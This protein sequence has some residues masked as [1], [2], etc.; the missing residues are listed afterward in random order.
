[1][2]EQTIFKLRNFKGNY[3]F[4]FVQE[5]VSFEK[6]VVAVSRFRDTKWAFPGLHYLRKTLLTWLSSVSINYMF[7][8]KRNKY[9]FGHIPEFN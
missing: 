5:L 7:I 6:F 8:L 1:M 9:I 4:L 3:I 2:I